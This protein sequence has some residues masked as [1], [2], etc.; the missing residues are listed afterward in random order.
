MDF[1]EKMLV[2]VNIAFDFQPVN[3]TCTHLKN[4]QDANEAV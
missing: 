1:D 2:I 3:H 4:I